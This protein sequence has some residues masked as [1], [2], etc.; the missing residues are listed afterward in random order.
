MTA[1]I[2][3]FTIMFMLNIFTSLFIYPFRIGKPRAAL[4]PVD[5]VIVLLFS[6]IQGFF[7]FILWKYKVD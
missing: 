6:L 7:V 3:Y 5:L 1:A 2:W 4:T